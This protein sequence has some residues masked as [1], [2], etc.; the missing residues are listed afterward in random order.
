[1]K[2]SIHSKAKAAL[3][4]AGPI[5]L[6]LAAWWWV[7]W[8]KMIDR[9]ILPGPAAVS[10]A[11]GELLLQQLIPDLLHT[12]GRT[13]A[14]LSLAA[15]I[16]IPAGL[17]F[18]LHVRAYK[19]VE[20]IIH[21]LRS[22]PA[23][24]LFP[25]FLVAIGVGESS[26]IALATYNSLMVILINTVTGTLLANESRLYHAR[27]LG[28]GSWSLTTEVLFW[29]ALPHILG[30]LRIALGYCLALVIAVEMFIG[31]SQMGLGRKIYEFQAAYRTPETYAPIIVTSTLG[32][33]MN[34]ILG[35][36]ERRALRWH[37]DSKF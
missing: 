33:A 36:V 13:L 20:G 25:L 5:A 15:V 17:W 9:L 31:V 16:G 21:A 27:L 12:L 7:T 10:R 8:R 2:P 1:M 26:L 23:A 18:G 19:A 29:E 35:W 32:I 14:A 30:G 11:F 24:A 4:A 34:L 22:V 6:L 3:L 28:L 37:P